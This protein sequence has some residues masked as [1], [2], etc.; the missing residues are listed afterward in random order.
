MDLRKA[1]ISLVVLAACG[2]DPEVPATIGTAA[3]AD[4][5]GADAS[6]DAS[7]TGDTAS[8]DTTPGDSA[9]SDASAQDAGPS[10]AA[11][12]DANANDV[13]PSDA[14][15]TDAAPA[16][17]PLCSQLLTCVGVACSSANTIDCAAPCLAGASA[18]ASAAIKPFLDCTDQA[19]AKGLCAGSSDPKCLGNCGW[20]KCLTP[21]LACGADGKSGTADCSSA[22]GCLEGCKNQGGNC[23]FNCY[24]ALSPTAQVQL[25]NLS[26][27]SAAAGNQDAFSVC[28]NQALTCLTGGKT[29]SDDCWKLLGCTSACDQG[30]DAV[31]AQCVGTCWSKASKDAQGQWISVLQCGD[32]STPACA[33]P[34]LTC[35]Q[36]SGAKTCL[37]TLGCWET[38]SKAAAGDSCGLQCLRDASPAEGKKVVD[39]MQCIA[40]QCG[41]CKGDQTCED[42]CTQE[43]CKPALTGCLAP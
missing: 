15:A 41:S 33:T 5:A 2:A 14:N 27:C 9:A 22:F 17:Y 21:A 38:C 18:A 30:S 24:A 11:A 31:K 16:K 20:D 37:D 4:G 12:N 25:N 29:G 28:P 10:D 8:S 6:F 39:L 35:V 23:A 26:A 40:Q 7:A 43:K 1:L 42:K 19:C 32:S 34:L 36:P 13:N 3:G